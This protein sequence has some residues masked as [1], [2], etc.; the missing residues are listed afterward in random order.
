MNCFTSRVT[1]KI[2]SSIGLV[3]I[4]VLASSSLSA[5]EADAGK[6]KFVDFSIEPTSVAQAILQ[7]T[8]QSGIQVV[9]STDKLRGLETS[10]VQGKM[11]PQNALAALLKDAQVDFQ[12]VGENTVTV[13][14][15]T[16][17]SDKQE[18][19][20]E[21]ESRVS[22]QTIE[23][24][25]VTATKRETSLQD[26]PMSITALG[27][28]EIESRGLVGAEDYLRSVPN[29]NYLEFTPGFSSVT[30]RGLS[31][32]WATPDLSSSYLGEV[33]LSFSFGRLT[34]RS[35]LKL[36]D[37]DR[38]EVLRGPQG[39]LYGANSMS[40]L[41]RN[42]PK[43][44]KLDRFEGSIDV[45]VSGLSHASDLSN[46]QVGVLNVPL[47]DDRLA[48]RVV[49]YRFDNA[50]FRDLVS[51][52]EIENV[53]ASTGTTVAMV[54]DDNPGEFVGGRAS[55]LWE[56]SDRLKLTFMMSRQ[57]DELGGRN[58]YSAFEPGVGGYRGIALEEEGGF[59]KTTHEF[60]H[61]LLEYDL[62]WAGLTS[63]STWV[64]QSNLWR[65]G[66]SNY[67]VFG[68]VAW[69]AVSDTK[70]KGF[71]Q[72]VRLSS[73]LDGPLQF[74][75]GIYY[76]D[77]DTDST[78][79][80][81]W[82]GTQAS[83]EALGWAGNDPNRVWNVVASE[84]TR[85]VALFGELEY[86]L[87]PQWQLTL[88]G[89][90]FKYDRDSGEEGVK[91]GLDAPPILLGVSEKDNTF[92][93]GV[94]YN[95]ND[96]TMLYASWGQGFRL[97][98]GQ[99]VPPASVCDINGDGIL[100]STNAAIKDQINTDRTENYELGA[101]LSL[102]DNQLT[103]NATLYRVDWSEIPVLVRGSC[104]YAVTVNSGEA[105]SQGL[106][107]DVRYQ[108]LSSLE[109]S[110][111]AAY[112]DTEFLDDLIGGNGDRLP[113]SPEYNGNLGLE[114]QFSLASHPAFVRTDYAFTG[115]FFPDI[116]RQYPAI[117]AH[118][119]LSL[120]TGV[121]LERF[122]LQI[123][124]KNLVGKDTVIYQDTGGV[125]R[126]SPREIGLDVKYRFE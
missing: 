119:Q 100:D 118:G 116:Y 44:P 56:A 86:Q 36:M 77:I 97:G 75:A 17:G 47:V 51:T 81:I 38:V 80:Q 53:A 74:T 11:Y 87:N 125:W 40:G 8:D 9:I 113:W 29:V 70:L 55:L 120:R 90:W 72:E 69:D 23:E 88:G 10:G 98:R 18:R 83:L 32:G 121:D 13:Q 24:M 106:E 65:W 14:E 28:E 49:A 15:R 42:I 93:A 2:I 107:L 26:T 25:I 59:R 46:K 39:T 41:V 96:N 66:D 76:E 122:S 27:G 82:I 54:E 12:F 62:G 67:Y 115:E 45:G 34:N 78:N 101:R 91:L 37:M 1:Q 89:R 71:V 3:S 16:G 60:S 102:L 6:Q 110:L 4:V 58:A 84:F 43:A 112:T 48:L 114:Y 31:G 92:R 73:Q 5:N 35:D 21:K 20:M 105:R 50:G 57:E 126:L 99:S 61:V 95:P 108:L 7:F 30:I 63:A 79:D 123:Y 68:N 117:D 64:D 124:G 104:I 22:N 111:G 85:Q 94:R 52:P 19:A 33:P 103:V 109:L